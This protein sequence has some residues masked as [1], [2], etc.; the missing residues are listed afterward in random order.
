VLDRIWADHDDD[1]VGSS[2]AK[3]LERFS[4]TNR[5]DASF[6]LNGTGLSLLRALATGFAFGGQYQIWL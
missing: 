4:S 3:L 1:T 5:I 6:L 2:V